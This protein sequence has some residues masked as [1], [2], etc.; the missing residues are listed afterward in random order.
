[1]RA[2]RSV[3]TRSLTAPSLCAKV[4][5]NRCVGRR[6]HRKIFYRPHQRNRG[7]Q[8]GAYRC[9]RHSSSF[10]GLLGRNLIP[11]ASTTLGSIFGTHP[12]AIA[13]AA[14]DPDSL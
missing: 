7:Q 5:R 14:P 12:D 9:T 4:G 11:I 13:E 10:I 3:G 2:G 1:M 6:E 8:D